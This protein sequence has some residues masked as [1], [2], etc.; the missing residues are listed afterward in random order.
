[1]PTMSCMLA[2][3][4]SYISSISSKTSWPN[5]VSQPEQSPTVGDEV[6][7]YL[8]RTGVHGGVDRQNKV[9]DVKRLAGQRIARV[10]EVCR[11]HRGQ[12]STA[13]QADRGDDS[14]SELHFGRKLT[15]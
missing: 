8:H 10:L 12:H 7:P 1:M 4:A 13:D 14:G 5:G 9:L 3:T 6:F 2:K 11:A 15:K